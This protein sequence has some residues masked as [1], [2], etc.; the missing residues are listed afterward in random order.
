MFYWYFKVGKLAPSLAKSPSEGGW[1][2]LKCK[3][4]SLK[5]QEYSL[6]SL[7]SL[8]MLFSQGFDQLDL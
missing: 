6:E 3:N 2:N 8:D 7:S 4:T 1:I 5:L